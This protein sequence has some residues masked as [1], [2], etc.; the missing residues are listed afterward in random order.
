[1]PEKGIPQPIV[2]INRPC[3][4]HGD[5]SWFVLRRDNT[6]VCLECLLN[7][8]LGGTIPFIRQVMQN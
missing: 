1:M 5:N 4:I 6:L 7:D 2:I 3:Q 8:R